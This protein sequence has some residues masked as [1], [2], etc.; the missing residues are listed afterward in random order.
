MKKLCM[1]K[2]LGGKILEEHYLLRQQET[3]RFLSLLQGKGKAGEAVELGVE[4][5]TL[6]NNII[7]KMAL[8]K[9]CSENN[10]DME[11]IKKMVSDIIELLGTFVISD[12]FPPFFR[13]LFDFQ[14]IN[15]RTTEARGKNMTL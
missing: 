11:D 10:S 8:S 5:L 7:T 15:K 12:F 2:F 4:L 9:T 14:G 1:S 6:A 3:L 13:N